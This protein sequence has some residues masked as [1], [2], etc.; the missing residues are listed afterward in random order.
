M[1]I[2]LHTFAEDS[3][4]AG[5]LAAELSVTLSLVRTHTLPDSECLPRVPKGEQ[6]TLVY[7][8]LDRPDAKQVELLLVA[9]ALRG[10]VLV[11]PYLP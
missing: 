3:A 2:A 5:R 6:T 9:D 1:S 7:R 8:S 4:P 10:L 11:A